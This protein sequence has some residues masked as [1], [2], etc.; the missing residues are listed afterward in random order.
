MRIAFLC[1]EPAQAS[2]LTGD[3]APGRSL[4]PD[5]GAL[6]WLAW[7]YS[8]WLFFLGDVE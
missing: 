3:A 2:D 8:P 4:S 6:A 7:R 5:P 1:P